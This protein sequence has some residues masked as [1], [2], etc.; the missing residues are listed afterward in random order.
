MC[1]K[2]IYFLSGWANSGNFDEIN[3]L[4][5]YTLLSLTHPFVS[6]F[7]M[8]LYWALSASTRIDE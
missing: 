6:L 1:N 7:T 5:G 3:F 4:H 2:I 8:L